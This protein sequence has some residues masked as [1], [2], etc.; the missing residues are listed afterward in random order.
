[1]LEALSILGYD[2]AYNAREMLKRGHAEFLAEGLRRK[3]DGGLQYRLE[4][5]ESIWGEYSVISGEPASLF[6]AECICLYPD[7]K[8]ILTVR[9]SEG[10]WFQSFMK[11]IWFSER[12]LLASIV[13]YI[14]SQ[15]R[16]FSKFALGMLRYFYWNDFPNHGLRVYREH[17]A[18]VQRL[19]A[20]R[21][22]VY[23]TSHGWG[24][25]CEFLCKEKP[26]VDFPH[27]FTAAEHLAV[28]SGARKGVLKNFARKSMIRMGLP[29]LFLG[30]LLWRYDC[31]VD[32]WRSKA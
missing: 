8:V 3:Y 2:T 27:A 4:Q 16:A 5:F 13:P 22:L 18:M 1:M 28:F 24:P 23:N 31:A 19:A 21:V 25:L 15:F 29:V 20:G 10:V 17:N 6:A 11:T 7:A 12:T 9:E 14:D 26:G 32:L 30:T